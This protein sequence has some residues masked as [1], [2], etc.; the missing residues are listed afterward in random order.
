VSGQ[1][2]ATHLVSL[3]GISILLLCSPAVGVEVRPGDKVVTVG[4]A[5]VRAGTQTLATVPGETEFAAEAV[6]GEW[7]AVTTD[8][9]GKK[10]NGWIH[11]RHLAPMLPRTDLPSDAKD[12]KSGLEEARNRNK[13][14]HKLGMGYEN[15]VFAMN[16]ID[17]HPI[18]GMLAAGKPSGPKS[19]VVEFLLFKF[20]S[21]GE[22]KVFSTFLFDSGKLTVNRNSAGKNGRIGKIEYDNIDAATYLYC[23]PHVVAMQRVDQDGVVVPWDTKKPR[24]LY[25]AVSVYRTRVADV[26]WVTTAKTMKGTK[27]YKRPPII[28]NTVS[29]KTQRPCLAQTPCSRWALSGQQETTNTQRRTKPC[30]ARRVF[31]HSYWPYF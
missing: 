13:A 24:K 19:R 3:T 5:P 22:E 14:V 18:T 26:V 11:V 1:T 30:S 27:P 12:V 21:N 25:L 6:K 9:N 16:T 28:H 31:V 7:V 20:K 2:F 4:E 29:K 23:L 8:V 17:G 10:I 15:G